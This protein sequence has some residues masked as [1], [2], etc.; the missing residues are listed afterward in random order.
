MSNTLHCKLLDKELISGS[1]IIYPLYHWLNPKHHWSA[2][3]ICEDF[4]LMWKRKSP[5]NIINWTD[6]PIT[7]HRQPLSSRKCSLTHLH[8]IV[9][10]RI[11]YKLDMMHR[12]VNAVVSL[13]ISRL[14]WTHFRPCAK[15][16]VKPN[17]WVVTCLTIG[18]ACT[19]LFCSNRLE[20]YTP[21]AFNKRVTFLPSTRHVTA[22]CVHVCYIVCAYDCIS[23]LYESQHTDNATYTHKAVTECIEAKKL[24]SHWRQLH[25]KLCKG[26][27]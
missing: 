5:H 6:Q 8:S 12:C 25:Y 21:I 4:R 27:L 20:T 19:H 10:V 3:I 18:H 1:S 13:H 17:G 14:L 9:K 22:L 23:W 16:E 26:Q 2:L 24:L 11:T 7:T 15:P